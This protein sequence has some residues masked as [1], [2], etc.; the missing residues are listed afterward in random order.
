MSVASQI[1]ADESL[2][3]R[4]YSRTSAKRARRSNVPHREFMPPNGSNNISVDRLTM[5]EQDGAD[6]AN[7]AHADSVTRSGPFRGWAVIANRDA[8]RN[9]RK[10]IA[11]PTIRNLYHGDISLPKSARDDRDEQTRHAQELADASHW[12]DP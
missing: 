12:R 2:G 4:F 7:I 8:D 5:A 9:G 6:I 11:S 1:E 10:T 3:R